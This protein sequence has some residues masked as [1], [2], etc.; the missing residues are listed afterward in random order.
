MSDLA[1]C[2]ELT[3]GGL[4]VKIRVQPKASRNKIGEVREGYLQVKLTSP[5]VEGAANKMLIE[6]LSKKLRIAKSRVELLSGEKS[7][8]KKALLREVDMPSF[9]KIFGT[10]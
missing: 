3:P 5:P 6:F 4:K 10:P 7:R 9:E 8:K 2:V 1:S